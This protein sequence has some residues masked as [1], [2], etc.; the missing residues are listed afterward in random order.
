MR[1]EHARDFRTS[2]RKDSCGR[3]FTM[4]ELVISVTVFTLLSAIALIK[5]G[6]FNVKAEFANAAESIV[7]ALRE[8][9]VY[10]VASKSSVSGGGVP[11]LCGVVNS[12]FD[13]IYGVH[14]SAK[15]GQNSKISIFVDQNTN[16]VFDTGEPIAEV[17]AW[18]PPIT[19]AEVQCNKFGVS[20]CYDN[21]MDITFRRP[22]PDAFIID[23]TP[24]T[25]E[26][27]LPPPCI[28]A[29]DTAPTSQDSY[30]SG[31]IIL[32]NGTTF[33]TTT[34]TLTGQVSLQ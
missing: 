24:C 5:Y 28:K 4:I 29:D 12:P 8:A 26:G 2:V 25:K 23:I 32:T 14:F 17:I 19:I 6:S 30:S 11:V 15:P 7:I 9:Q 20:A 31:A 13:C 27:V 22:N 3:G 10:G 21:Q 16:Y 1:S 18:N 33:S 34:I